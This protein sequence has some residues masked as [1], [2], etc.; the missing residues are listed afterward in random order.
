MPP[1]LRYDLSSEKENA[2]LDGEPNP[3]VTHEHA[4]LEL[5]KAR[6]RLQNGEMDLVE[7]R[8]IQANLLKS[9]GF[10]PTK[11]Y[12]TLLSLGPPSIQ[13]LDRTDSAQGVLSGL[14]SIKQEEQYIQGLDA[15]LEGTSSA[16]RPYAMNNLGSRVTEKNTER[17]RE[18]QLRNPVSV[19]NWLRKHQPQV[20]L[21]DN[22]TG[23]DKTPRAAG[24][25]SSARKF[26]Q[27]KDIIKQE[28]DY[29]DE[30]FAADK[31]PSRSKRKRDDD[32]GYR[33][34]G[35]TSRGSKRRKETKEDPVRAKRAKKQST[36][37]I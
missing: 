3:S 27:Q 15:Y 35:G 18:T 17:E 20:F 19:Y 12:P 22:E 25:R 4:N 1:R 14:L 8:E 33:P 23:V 32:G 21:Q 2:P 37:A 28:K 5:Q 7:Y 9:P 26:A 29:D 24:S 34:K 31:A 11:S 13:P 6:A 30:G 16:P 36:E 10:A